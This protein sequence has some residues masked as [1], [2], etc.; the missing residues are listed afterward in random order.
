MDTVQGEFQKFE[1][2][3]TSPF[4]TSIPM[5]QFILTFIVFVIIAH[6]VWDNLELFKKGISQ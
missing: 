6:M 4:T 2:W 5:W 3:F 1:K